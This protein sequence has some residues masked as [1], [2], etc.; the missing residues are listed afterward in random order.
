[1]FRQSQSKTAVAYLYLVVLALVLISF[2]LTACGGSSS[3]V[4]QWQHLP[5]PTPTPLPTPTPSGNVLGD[6]FG[7]LVS[8]LTGELPCD[9]MYPDTI[10]FFRDGTIDWGGLS[11]KYDK[12][13]NGRIR[14]EI[15][16]ALVSTYQFS[17]SGE[18]LILRDDS[19]CEI[20]YQR[21]SR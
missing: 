17:I 19:G 6:L 18:I 16:G 4:G 7:G 2:L 5:N 15:G 8:G 21:V 1:M 14:I 3:L 10:E 12:I 11:G 13:D 20:R 9:A